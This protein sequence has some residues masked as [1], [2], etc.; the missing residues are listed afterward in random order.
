MNFRVFCHDLI[1]TNVEF[2]SCKRIILWYFCIFWTDD[3]IDL[4]E[5]ASAA[6][7]LSQLAAIKPLDGMNY[8]TWR[9]DIELMLALSELDFALR[10]AR[11]V[12]PQVGEPDFDNKVMKHVLE[13]AKWERSNRK[14]LMVLKRSIM[15]AIR[16]SIPECETTK[17]Y[18]DRVATQFVGSS[19]AYASTVTK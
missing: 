16:G 13:R 11:P 7:I 2:N 10:S 1:L 19:K 14:C 5:G 9:E 6:N 3:L 18:L 15:E 4:S 12:P 8:S 17:E